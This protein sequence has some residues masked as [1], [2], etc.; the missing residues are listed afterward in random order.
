MEYLGSLDFLEGVN[1][2]I[3]VVVYVLILV[4]IAAFAFWCS[5]ACPSLFKKSDNFADKV[6]K[7][8]R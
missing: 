2:T 4:H 3:K 6:E 7:A 8:F 1:P 5:F